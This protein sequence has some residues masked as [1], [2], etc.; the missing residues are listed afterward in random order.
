MITAIEADGTERAE[1]IVHDLGPGLSQAVNDRFLVN[2]C[3]DV[4]LVA[5]SHDGLE[6]ARLS[7]RICAPGE[8]TI[9]R[10]PVASP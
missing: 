1:P 8:W 5:R 2:A 3:R 10:E 4:T 6:V 9:E 7:G